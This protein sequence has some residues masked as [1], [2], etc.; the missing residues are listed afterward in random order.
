MKN[1][2]NI[3]FKTKKTILIMIDSNTYPSFDPNHSQ[4]W[5]LTKRE[6]LAAMADLDEWK[7]SSPEFMES[8]VGESTPSWQLEPLAH[9]AFYAKFHAIIKCIK[10]DELIKELKNHLL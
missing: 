2:L 8:V 4:D 10:A 9:L 3:F 1:L 6:Y 5:G 7:D